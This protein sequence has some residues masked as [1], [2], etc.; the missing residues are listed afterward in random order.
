MRKNDF[1]IKYVDQNTIN[2]MAD[3]KSLQSYLKKSEQNP[4]HECSFMVNKRLKNHIKSILSDL[5]RQE[6]EVVLLRF[7]E[8]LTMDEIA[9]ALGRSDSDI[10]KILNQALA[11]IKE[12][13][14][15]TFE[16]NNNLNQR[17][18]KCLG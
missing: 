16:V 14:L 4:F 1:P 18:F 5:P 11:T 10:R 8:G 17:E 3:N 7:W 9:Y 6:K 15:S 13:I 2:R 12:K